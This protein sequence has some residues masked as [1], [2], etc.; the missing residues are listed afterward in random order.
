M[1]V[2]GA[3]SKRGYGR[4]IQTGHTL[5]LSGL[6]GITLYEPDELVLSA[7]AGTPLAEIRKALEE[8]NQQLAFEPS[9]LS[10]LYGEPEG[11]GTLGGLIATNLAGPRRVMAGAARDYFLGFSGVSGRGETFKSGGRVMK[12]V[13]GYDLSKLLCGSFGTLAAMSEVTLKV[14][15][16]PEKT[17][18]VLVFGL[19]DAEACKAMTRALC[20]SYEVS[21]AAHLPAAVAGGSDVSY[22][23]EAGGGVTAL[24]SFG[25]LSLREAA[26]DPGRS[27]ADGGAAQSQLHDALA[28]DRR[29]PALRRPAGAGRVAPL[30]CAS[31]HAGRD[32]GAARLAAPGSV[33]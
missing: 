4:P 33:L 17:R 31:G 16:A 21:G 7:Q 20:S 14:L 18:S 12:N 9:D 13:T 24:R 6:S 15:P 29:S 26:G 19:D 30:D 25:G 10:A 2:V 8:R 1:E 28:G 23:A 32:C 3:G 22:V 27:W 11:A 5:D